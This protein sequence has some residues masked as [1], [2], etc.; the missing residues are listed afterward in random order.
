MEKSIF[1]NIAG[2]NIQINLKPTEWNF[3]YKKLK[4]DICKH[5]SGFIIK[6]HIGKIDYFIDINETSSLLTIIKK[7]QLYFFN[8]FENIRKNKI[9]TYYQISLVQ[10]QMVLREVLL[11]LLADNHGF[12]MHGSAVNKAY[13]AS[14]IFT[15]KNGAGKSTA[16]SLLNPLFPALADDTVIVKKEKEGYY[17]YQ[18]PFI[19]KNDWVKKSGKRFFINKIFFIKK[20]NY[21]KIEKINDKN[22][23]TQKLIQQ[24]WTKDEVKKKQIKTLFEFVSEYNNFYYLYFSKNKNKLRTFL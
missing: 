14:Y 4:N 8:L 23:L 2:F 10:F 22:L 21:F 1:L 13:D 17:L 7:P 12:I 6:D 5:Y 24:F 18:T 19:E 16:M 9:V 20:A 3:V 11:D 15:G